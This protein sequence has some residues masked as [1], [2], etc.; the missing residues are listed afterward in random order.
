LVQ[1]DHRVILGLLVL[2][3]PRVILVL[4]VHQA[5][6]AMKVQKVQEV[7]KVSWGRKALMVRLG[8]RVSKV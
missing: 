1:R 6:E 3:A 4:L 5:L 8:H 2:Q 7:H